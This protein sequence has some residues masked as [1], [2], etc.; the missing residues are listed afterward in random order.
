MERL[1]NGFQKNN[2]SSFNLVV[3]WSVRFSYNAVGFVVLVS[4]VG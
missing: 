4:C 3:F 1:E 2:L